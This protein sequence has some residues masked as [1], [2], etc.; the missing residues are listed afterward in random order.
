MGTSFAAVLGAAPSEAPPAGAPRSGGMCG[1]S[2]GAGDGS[3]LRGLPRGGMRPGI[4]A[5]AM[6]LRRAVPNR[7]ARTFLGQPRCDHARRC[8]PWTEGSAGPRDAHDHALRCHRGRPRPP[9]RVVRFACLPDPGRSR[10][11]RLQSRHEHD[12]GAGAGPPVAFGGRTETRGLDVAERRSP[13]AGGVVGRDLAV[14]AGHGPAELGGRQRALPGRGGPTRRHDGHDPH[15]QVAPA[16]VEEGAR[17]R[18]GAIQDGGQSASR[19]DTAGLGSVSA[20]V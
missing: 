6:V 16:R 4:V 18:L 9:A 15:V 14:R 17:E 11:L 10:V 1:R 7:V 5:A 20:P 19:R 13:I 3:S 12:S 2:A 8:A